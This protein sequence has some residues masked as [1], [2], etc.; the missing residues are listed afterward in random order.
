MEDGKRTNSQMTFL[1]IHSSPAGEQPAAAAAAEGKEE[2]KEVVAEVEAQPK[3]LQKAVVAAAE[4]AAGETLEGTST[5][6]AHLFL[7]WWGW[8]VGVWVHP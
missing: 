6:S 1:C 2:V 5:V 8:G 3:S 7:C 4:R